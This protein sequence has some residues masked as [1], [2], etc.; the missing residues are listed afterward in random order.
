[1][2]KKRVI[3]DIQDLQEIRGHTNSYDSFSE[4][5]E[6]VLGNPDLLPEQS[7]SP[8]SPQLLMGE[9]IEH[10][11]GRQKEVYIAIMRDD[12]SQ[13]ET[14]ELLGVGRTTVQVHLDRAIAFIT[15][16]CRRGM[17]KERI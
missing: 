4:E 12:K 14:A 17:E 13:A 1:M 16:Y 10:L 5:G 2:K 3:V 8:S 6:S 15:E 7:N 11:Q 9:A